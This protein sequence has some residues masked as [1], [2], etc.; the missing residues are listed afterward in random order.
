M[1][2]GERNLTCVVKESFLDFLRMERET[3]L[4]MLKNA[5]ISGVSFE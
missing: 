5:M 1:K 4:H 3:S 2:A